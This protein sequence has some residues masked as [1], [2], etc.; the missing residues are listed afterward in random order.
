MHLFTVWAPDAESVDL[1]LLAGSAASGVA[2]DGATVADPPMPAE[3]RRV[4]MLPGD[5]GW[6]ALEVADAG[7]GT[8]YGFCVGGDVPLPD[9]RSGWQP[10]GV[11]GPS[12]VFDASRHD[13]SDAGWRGRDVLGA[14]FYEL[15]IGTFTAE[16]T[17][18]AAVERLDHLVDLGVDVVEVMPVAAFQGRHGWGYDGVDLYAVHEPYGGPAGFQVFVDAC[19]VRGLAVCLDVVYNHL[20]PAGN[21]LSRF[22]PYF[23]DQHHTP[24]GEAVNLADEGRAQVRRFVCDNAL[25]WFED[26]H[27]DCLRLDAV[28]ALVDESRRH[29]LA[30][31]SGEVADLSHRL[32]RPLSLVAESDLNDPRMVEPVLAGGLGMTAQWSDDL[33]H[34]LHSVLTGEQQGYYHDFGG[35]HGVAILARTLTRVFRHAGH[36]STFRKATWGAPVDPERHRGHRF[37]GY[38]Q[39]HDQVGNRA[40]GDRIGASVSAGRL[41]IGAAVVLTSPFTPMLFMGEEWAASTPW[42]FF[43]DHDPELGALV[44]QGRRSEFAAHGWAA[45]DVPDPQDPAT[46]E[47]SRLDW[48]EADK[49]LGGRMLGWYAALVALRRAEPDLRADDLRDVRVSSG[50]DWFVVHRGRFDVAVNLGPEPAVLP[51]GP[52]ARVVLDWAGNARAADGGVRLPP[53]GVAV[54]RHP[55]GG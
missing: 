10:Y 18:D 36:W 17:F 37:L 24:W 45:S 27:V 38:L 39:N 49:E 7:H 11:H 55:D 33:H 31:L 8:D 48:A 40:R 16:G 6:W 35:P 25:R 51:V 12:R 46:L 42:M 29:V 21:Y 13:W 28:H 5:N 23:T 19:H 53:D 26:F 50:A 34:A 22:G 43:T 14:V 9:P 15:H 54:L 20:G 1:F 2:A 30:Q 32:G 3:G 52:G 41:A 47:A 4:S 44:S